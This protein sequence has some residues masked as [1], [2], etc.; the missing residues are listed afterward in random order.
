[1]ARVIMSRSQTAVRY[2][3][4]AINRGLE[5][6]LEEGLEMEDRLFAIVLQTEDAKEGT[7]AYRERRRPV[8]G[9]S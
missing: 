2:A 3:K 7:R 6:S 9:K 5:L 8:F 4:Q 1:M